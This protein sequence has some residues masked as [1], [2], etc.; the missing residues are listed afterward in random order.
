M[1]GTTTAIGE[2]GRG[3]LFTKG[4]QRRQIAVLVAFTLIGAAVFGLWQ[5]YLGIVHRWQT[6][7]SRAREHA[8]ATAR[9]IDR[10]TSAAGQLLRNLSTSPALEKGN[11]EAFY[12]QMR[13]AA[14]SCF[15]RKKPEASRP[16]RSQVFAP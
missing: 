14:S 12:E 16:H 8:H 5:S 9:L 15:R 4:R 10:E 3:Q 1:S 13:A 6:L 7:E 2:A 11:L